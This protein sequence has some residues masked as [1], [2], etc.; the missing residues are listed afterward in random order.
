MR[1]VDI[2]WVV[3]SS[4]SMAPKQ[5]RLAANFNGF[6]NQLVTAN[7]P[8]DFHIAV[9]TTDTDDPAARGA[10]KRVVAAGPDR[11]LHRLHAADDGRSPATPAAH[12]HRG[13]RPSTADRPRSASPAAPRSAASTPPTWRS[14]TRSTSPPPA[15]ERFVR[16]DASLYVVVVSDEDDSSCTPLAQ[17]AICTADPGCRCAPDTAL[18]STGGLGLDRST[19]P[20][21]SRPTRATATPTRWRSRRSWRSTRRRRAVA[22]RRPEPARGLLPRAQRHAVPQQRH[23]RRRLRGGLLR[24]PLREGGG[25]H[26]RGGG[27]IC[28]EPTSV[29]G[30]LAALGYAAS[31]LRREFRL[32]RGPE[33]LPMAGGG[34]RHSL[35]VSPANAANC[36]VD[37]NCPTGARSARTTAAP[38]R[39]PSRRGAA[40]NGAEYVKCDTNNLRNMVRFDGTAVPESLSPSTSATTCRPTS[41]TPVLEEVFARET[42]PMNSQDAATARA[43]AGRAARASQR[44]RRPTTSWSRRWRCA[45]ALFTAEGHFEL[46][47]ATSASRSC[48]G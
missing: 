26:R 13:R 45:T 30:A 23:Q 44:V 43:S 25:G 6:I 24:Q 36:T 3:D 7:P 48:R 1:K 15:V 27:D 14:P 11:R 35:F 33:L 31:G 32:T 5:A 40:P 28:E 47:V 38:T 42:K 9:T 19:S 12:R 46:G 8:I 17:Q 41:R 21:S 4:G 18:S 22:V 16:A 2:L 34:D 39:S 10:L 20:A 29:S 37:G